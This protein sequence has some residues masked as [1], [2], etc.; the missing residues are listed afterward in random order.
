M[1]SGKRRNRVNQTLLVLLPLAVAT[2]LFAN[3]IGSGWWPAPA[4]I[5]GAVALAVVLVTPWKAPIVRRGLAKRKLASVTS[6]GLLAMI[7]VAL[8]TGLAHSSGLVSRIGPLTIMQV[9]IGSALLAVTLVV[10]H[11]R[12]HP[13][14]IRRTDL[15]RRA[16]LATATMGAAAATAW[17][18][19]EGVLQISGLRGRARRFTG[20]HERG[21]FDPAAMPVTSWFDDDVP[22]IDGATWAVDIAGTPQS[23]ADLAGRQREEVIALLDCTSGWYSTQRWEGVR[24][25]RLLSTDARSIAVRS[26]TGYARRF[27]VRDLDRLWL[28]TDVGGRPLSP[29]HGYPARLVA[30]G[31]RGFWWV[32][33]VVAIEPSDLPWWWQLPFP[34]T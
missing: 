6:L 28:V 18:A 32:K 29:G 11:Y 26:A 13:R 9:H 34:A 15:D 30:P 12:A 1:S 20:S 23:L 33:W 14:P 4:A 21:S 3:T 31:R 27:P 5:H 16:F 8:G 7:V 19:W 17:F 2:G 10:M 25:D 22:N 24:L